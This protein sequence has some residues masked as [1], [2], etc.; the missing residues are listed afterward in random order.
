M[1][2]KPHSDD[3][4]CALHLTVTRVRHGRLDHATSLH[5]RECSRNDVFIIYFILRIF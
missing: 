5:N 3:A 1:Y 2:L 4:T